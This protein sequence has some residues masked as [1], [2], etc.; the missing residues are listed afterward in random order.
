M[1]ADRY[2]CGHCECPRCTANQEVILAAEKIVKQI[3]YGFGPDLKSLEAAVLKF[4]KAQR[5]KQ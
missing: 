2:G 4:W 5:G 3:Q 1:G